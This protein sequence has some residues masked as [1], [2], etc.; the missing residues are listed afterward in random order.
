VYVSDDAD[1]SSALEVALVEAFRGDR[2]LLNVRP[3]GELTHIGQSPFFV[4][5]SFSY[6]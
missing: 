5:V 1:H 6:K 3:G 2:R 4:Y